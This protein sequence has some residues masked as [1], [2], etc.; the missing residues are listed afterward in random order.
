MKNIYLVGFMATGKSAVGKELARQKKMRFLDLD[1]FIE[2]REKREIV[3]I[4]AQDGEAYFRRLEKE[5]L[6]EISGMQDCVVSCGG[7]IVIDPANI[8]MMKASGVIICLSATAKVILERTRKSR[9]R[10][11][12]NVAD[13]EEKIASLLK[14]RAPYYA[15]ADKTI[16]TSKISVKEV[17]RAA[18]EFIAEQ[19]E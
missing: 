19:N 5:N 2:E 1:Q 3:E 17:V 15:Q 7:G 6:T 18:L 14:A 11:L 8:R 16:D 10:P 13:P 12:L 4:F 9:N